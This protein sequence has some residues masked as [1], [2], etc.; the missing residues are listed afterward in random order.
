M[1]NDEAAADTLA[2]VVALE[3]QNQR[4]HVDSAHGETRSEWLAERSR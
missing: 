2:S 3:K 4:R 1:S